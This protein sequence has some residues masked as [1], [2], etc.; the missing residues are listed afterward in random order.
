MSQKSILQEESRKKETP[1]KETNNPVYES[2]DDR[3]EWL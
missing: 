1:R 3:E 2:I